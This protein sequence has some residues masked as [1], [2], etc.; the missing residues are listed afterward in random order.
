MLARAHVLILNFEPG[1]NPVTDA[2]R[3]H[4]QGS[5]TEVANAVGVPRRTFA[6]KM[7]EMHLFSAKARSGKCGYCGLY[8]RRDK[9]I[10]SLAIQRVRDALTDRNSKERLGT[11]LGPF[12]NGPASDRNQPDPRLAP[13]SYRGTK[14][15]II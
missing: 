12:G 10:C 2:P 13:A 8:D 3:R 1:Y 9:R 5:V 7:K 4:K 6:R 15:N 11:R 14:P